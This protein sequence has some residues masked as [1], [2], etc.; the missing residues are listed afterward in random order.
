MKRGRRVGRLGVAR[1]LL[2]LVLLQQ[3]VWK[4]RVGLAWWYERMRTRIRRKVAMT[5][6]W[7]TTKTQGRPLKAARATRGP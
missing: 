6:E 7:R 2:V 5:R 3:G 4:K 1:L